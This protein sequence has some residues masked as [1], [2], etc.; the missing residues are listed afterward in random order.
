MGDTV[1]G[2]DGLIYRASNQRE[3]IAHHPVTGDALPD[4]ETGTVQLPSARPGV[5]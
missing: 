2:N 3:K 5:P 1:C 4:M